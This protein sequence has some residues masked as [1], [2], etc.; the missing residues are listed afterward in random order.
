M[1][2][3]QGGVSTSQF[4]GAN[5]VSIM[6]ARFR[7]NQGSGGSWSLNAETSQT[8]G[9]KGR[10]FGGGG[11]GG[12]TTTIIGAIMAFASDNRGRTVQGSVPMWGSNKGD[13]ID[14]F[15]TAACHVQVWDAWPDE[16]TTWIPQYM[17]A[18]HFNPSI[19]ISGPL[20]SQAPTTVTVTDYANATRWG[21]DT[22]SNYNLIGEW[23]VKP[24][25]DY[26]ITVGADTEVSFRDPTYGDNVVISYLNEEGVWV[27]GTYA[28][29]GTN[30][31][32]NDG[33]NEAGTSQ[34][35]DGSAVRAGETLGP[36][37]VL[38]Q[39]DIW[40]INRKREAQ[41]VTQYGYAYDRV[42]MGL[43]A[44]K[45]NVEMEEGFVSGSANE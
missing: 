34:G 16:L 29:Y 43:S 32:L 45:A 21:R 10:F 22:A 36:G 41:L 37:T 14:S 4:V 31:I 7:L 17:C 18:L 13:A 40:N 30:N 2:S 9:M 44:E 23:N 24:D 25:E 26:K 42:Q 8:F 38:R 19:E 5:A 1:Q 20:N 15:G 3:F 28:S 12:I 6:S 33:R 27:D 11:G 35:A 39:N